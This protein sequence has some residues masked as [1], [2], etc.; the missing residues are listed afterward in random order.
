MEA[1]RIAALRAK[2]ELE[3]QAV[4]QMK[5]QEQ[6]V[7]SQFLYASLLLLFF[8]A[9]NLPAKTAS[10]G[11]RYF[12]RDNMRTQ[13][14]IMTLRLCFFILHVYKCMNIKFVESVYE[15]MCSYYEK[16]LHPT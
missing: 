11:V 3:R 6:L 12:N 16:N 13:K 15:C 10:Y 7:S 8:V 5:S 14:K 9:L 2:E 4:D 1:E